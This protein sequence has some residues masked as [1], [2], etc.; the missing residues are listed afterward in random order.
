MPLELLDAAPP[1][2]PPEARFMELLL[3]CPPPPEGEP[4]LESALSLLS[5][6]HALTRKGPINRTQ[7][8]ARILPPD[9]E[10]PLLGPS[11]AGFR[12]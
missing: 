10:R 4:P 9:F 11:R 1:E 6:L 7:S 5:E 12:A 2:Y 8:Q 3:P